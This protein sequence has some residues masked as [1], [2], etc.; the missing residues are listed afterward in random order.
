MPIF[1][2]EF[3]FDQPVDELNFGE[4]FRVL[5]PNPKSPRRKA[6]KRR[7]PK[8]QLKLSSLATYK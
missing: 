6:R 8:D 1:V 5:P 4:F 7:V 3:P 2:N